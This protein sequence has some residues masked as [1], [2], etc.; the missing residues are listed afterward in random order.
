MTC[1]SCVPR[2]R[3]YARWK[4][5]PR[6]ASSRK[7]RSPRGIATSRAQL[8]TEAVMAGARRANDKKFPGFDL[9]AH[10]QVIDRDVVPLQLVQHGAPCHEDVDVVLNGP[11]QL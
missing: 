11:H 8:F 4:S 3:P 6:A 2:R 5:L 10:L 7:C 1:A 9:D